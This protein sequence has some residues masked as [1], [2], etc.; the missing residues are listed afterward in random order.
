MAKLYVVVIVLALVAICLILLSENSSIAQSDTISFVQ[1]SI[2]DQTFDYPYGYAIDDLELPEATGGS[3][4]YNYSL[5]PDVP[6]LSFDTTT[7]TLSGT[8]TR[9]NNNHQIT[10]AATDA[11]D[12]AN[13]ATLNFSISVGPGSVNNIRATV[14][15]GAPSVALAWD[16]TSG[17]IRY[18]VDRC[19]GSCTLDDF[20]GENIYD[21]TGTT[22]TDTGVTLGQT[23]TYL[24]QANVSDGQNEK[25]SSRPLLIVLVEAPTPTPTPTATPEP[26]NTPTPTPTAT[27]TPTPTPTVT[28][29]PTN[30]PTPTHT[31]TPTPTHTLTP[32]PTATFTPTPTPTPTPTNTPTPTPTHTPTPTPTPTFTPTPTP[33]PIPS[34]PSI[35]PGKYDADYTLGTTI[36]SVILP[37]A[38]GGSGVFSY[39]LRPAVPGLIFDTT[40]RRLSG[41]PSS[42][43]EY[44]MTYTATDSAPDMGTTTLA[45]TIVVSPSEV[46]NFHATTTSSGT[47]IKL[48]W[49]SV[50]GA[51]GYDMERWSRSDR[52][53]VFIKDTSFGH[54]GTKTFLPD[55]TEYTDT[56]VIAGNEY[57]YR[58]SAYLKLAS[59]KL[60]YGDWAESED[61][62]IEPP[63]TPT[64]TPTAT[65]T[66]TL[67]PTPTPSHTPTVTPTPTS[68][69]TPTPTATAT[70]TP[71]HT[72][73][74]LRQPRLPLLLSLHLQ[75]LP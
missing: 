33:T 39:S 29:T 50:A 43:A 22:H 12:S 41:T 30:T 10:Y 8:P 14:N 67:T 38:M 58:L 35:P 9:F 37:Q 26:T 27:L 64:P 68:T 21:N 24:F 59:G 40:T 73:P 19:S 3:G 16:A 75:R 36:K 6:G 15:V 72:H 47:Q 70:P 17:A 5:S 57:F 18:Y 42:V 4:S 74:P 31:P 54:G 69:N 51:S 65:P 46:S 20:D 23:Y 2:A 56:G 60:R 71:T 52:D 48:G 61:I 13:S 32:T 34:F 1:N 66:P 63:P 53:G 28:P 11:D 55:A 62:Y 25:L 44:L 49:D 45:F 7:R